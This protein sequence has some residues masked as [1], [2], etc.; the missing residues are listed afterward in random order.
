MN[1]IETRSLSYAYGRQLAVR[2]LNLQVPKGSI[3]GFLGPNGAG[4]STTIKILLGLLRPAAGEAFLFEQPL[5]ARRRS[6]LTRVGALIEA[7]SLYGN[8]TARENLQ[9]LGRIFRFDEKRVEETLSLVELA[10]A[11]DKKVR[12]FSMGMKQRLGIAMA[13]VHEPDLLLLDEPVNG[14]DPSGIQ[15]MRRLFL[16]LRDAGKTLLISSHI[17]AEVEKVATHVGIIQDGALR[18]QGP[19]QELRNAT[20]PR[21]LL[22]TSDDARAAI[23]L[24]QLGISGILQSDKPGLEVHIGEGPEFHRLLVH[25]IDAAIEIYRVEHQQNSLEDLFFELTGEKTTVEE[26]QLF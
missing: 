14:L 24:R 8:L 11:A 21:I 1:I 25:F 2:N 16:R 9:W 4:K 12:Q 17:L 13:L 10:V 7:P 18:F 5:L 26:P 19:V 22:H 23:L 6:L 20:R 3:Y 15:A